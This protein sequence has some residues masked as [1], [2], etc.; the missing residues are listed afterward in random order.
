MGRLP[1][2]HPCSLEQSLGWC[3][4]W[5][6][7]LTRTVALPPSHVARE[8]PRAGQR[9]GSLGPSTC[10]V[11]APW[12]SSPATGSATC[13]NAVKEREPPQS[14]AGQASPMPAAVEGAQTACQ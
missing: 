8:G 14:S 13:A 4:L 2:P 11:L 7:P 6:P 9:L 1:S 3:A 12:G 5:P 10:Q